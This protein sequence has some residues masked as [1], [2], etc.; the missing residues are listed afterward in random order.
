[1]GEENDLDVFEE[2]WESREYLGLQTPD[3]SR[4]AERETRWPGA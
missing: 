2:D 3:L 4:R 1:V